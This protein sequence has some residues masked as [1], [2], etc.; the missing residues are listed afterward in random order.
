MK[1]DNENFVI[2]TFAEALSKCKEIDGE[3]EKKQK[4]FWLRKKLYVEYSASQPE[5]MEELFSWIY[6]APLKDW[7]NMVEVLSMSYIEENGHTTGPNL[8]KA[9]ELFAFLS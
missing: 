2:S 7:E 1:K 8:E 5:K 6:N 3:E 9:K 4:R